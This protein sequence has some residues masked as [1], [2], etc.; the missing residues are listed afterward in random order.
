M[1]ADWNSPSLADAYANFLTLI[2]ARDV[3]AICLQAPAVYVPTG[4]IKYNRSTNLFEE[5]SAAPADSAVWVVK[6]LSIAGG[7][8]GGIT[9]AAAR[10]N[11]GIGTLGTQSA[12]AVAITGGTVA[13]VDLTYT[14]ETHSIGT[15]AVKL[16]KIYN[17]HG[18]VAPVGTDKYLTS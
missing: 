5:N 4:A 15:N 11:L 9:A 8:T 1:G 18:A 6:V 17:K 10:S 13:D 3:D 7:G 12:A 2:K 14:A 16:S